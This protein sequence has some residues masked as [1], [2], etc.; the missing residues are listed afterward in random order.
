MERAR[1]AAN[2][3]LAWV[4]DNIEAVGTRI[5]PLVDQISAPNDLEFIVDALLA[6]TSL[7]FP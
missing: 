6:T 3:L 1:Q 5:Q 2:P 7:R 4:L